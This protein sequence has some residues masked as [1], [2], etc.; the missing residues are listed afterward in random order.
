MRNLQPADERKCRDIF[1][2]VGNIG[3]LILKAAEYD[4]RLS[5]CLILTVRR[6]LFFLASQ[7]EPYRV[8]NASVI[9][10]KLWSER[11]GRE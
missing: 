5:P 7:H 10:S 1:T 11:G 8:R 4:L 2:V 6:W 9:S 3:E